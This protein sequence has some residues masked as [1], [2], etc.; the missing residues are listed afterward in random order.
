M[1]YVVRHAGGQ[2]PYWYAVYRD[3]DNKRR[4]R[5]T[6]LTSKS[7]ALEMAH[8]L[9]KAH[10]EA[11]R[12]ALTEARARELLSEVL[13]TLTGESLRVFTVTQWFDQFV[14]QKKKSRADRTVKL[15]EQ[16]MREFNTLAS[17]VKQQNNLKL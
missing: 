12:H 16:M 9:E 11:R 5:S 3:Q 4:K 10:S 7:K 17:Y 1:A 6:K 13:E 14:N 15:H 2:S 8:T